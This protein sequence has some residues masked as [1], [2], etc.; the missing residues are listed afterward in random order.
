MPVYI[1]SAEAI[2]PQATFQSDSF[3]A[4]PVMPDRDYFSCIH[5]EYKQFINPA[6]LRRM[7]TVIRM[8][9]ATSKVCLENSGIGQPGAILIGSG[10]GCV[11]DTAKFLNQI[12][13][14][15]E[16]LLNPTAFIQSTHNTVSGQIALMLGCKAY[17]LTFSQKSISFETALLDAIMLLNENRAQTALVGGIDEIVEESFG[18]LVQG[19]CAKGQMEED[20]L[21]S[22]TPGAVA[23]E[24]ASFFVLSNEKTGQSMVRID[25]LEIVNRCQEVQELKNRLEAF[26]ARN[27]MSAD[28]LDLVVSGKNG[29][30]RYSGIYDAIH[31]W[32]SGSIITGYKHLVGEHDTASAFG[33][34]LASKIIHRNEV[35]EAVRINGKS[36]KRVSNGLV[37]NYNKDQDFTFTLLSKPDS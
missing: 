12:N 18:L 3:L 28:G 14:N 34:Y 9:L 11:H 22:T 2:S 6:S 31:Q 19:G 15:N 24:G 27:G 32:F 10:L 20:I 37:F 4:D 21:N 13:E 26:L 8:G 29:D 30:A 23:G 36:R 17:N 1:Q 7:S 33:M 16:Q 5:P 35:P 25:D